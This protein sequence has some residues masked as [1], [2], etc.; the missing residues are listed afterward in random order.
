LLVLKKLSFALVLSSVAAAL[1]FLVVYQIAIRVS[2]PVFH[3]PQTGET[4]PVMP[5]GQVMI[6]SFFAG[7]DFI[8][9]CIL[10]FRNYHFILEKLFKKQD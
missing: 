7:L 10:I 2:P 3:D 4:H 6:A 1:T 9:L 5:I 8:A